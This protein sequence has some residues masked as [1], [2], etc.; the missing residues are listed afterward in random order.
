MTH[1]DC[2]SGVGYALELLAQSEYH[3]QFPVGDYLRVEILPPLWQG[4]IRFYLSPQGFP[5]GMITWAWL[6]NE[7]LQDV[8]ASGRAL[9]PDEWNCGSQHFFNDWITPHN[10]IREIMQD[11]TTNVFPDTIATSLRRNPDGSVRRINRWTGV[12]AR[13]RDRLAPS[14]MNMESAG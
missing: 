14:N 5:T 8:L 1:I 4:Q 13:G 9:S 6:S 10:N 11:M 12:N 7:V 2:Y 3:R